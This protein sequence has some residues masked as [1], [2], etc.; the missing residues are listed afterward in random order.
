LASAV[1]LALLVASCRPKPADPSQPC[2]FLT[3]N[4][5]EGALDA[6]LIQRA[7]NPRNITLTVS[8]TRS[9]AESSGLMCS[10]T[11]SGP[12]GMTILN[13]WA[14]TT[15]E[16]EALKDQRSTTYTFSKEGLATQKTAP[17]TES[18]PGI[19]DAAYWNPSA[20][21][22]AAR[23]KDHAVVINGLIDRKAI[24]TLIKR[25]AARLE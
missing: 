19:G 7:L 23:K 9:H 10:I 14:A 11:A 4:E 17:P 3:D 13:V 1:I 22:A 16:F 5:L 2:S 21:I 6:A 20:A 15:S 12:S 24:I 25:A 8:G 18:L